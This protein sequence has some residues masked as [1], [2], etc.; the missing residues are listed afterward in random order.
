MQL[1]RIWSDFLFCF[2]FVLGVFR[3]RDRFL[4]GFLSGYSLLNLDLTNLFSFRFVVF[5]MK[6][7]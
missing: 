3:I 6:S 2:D 5:C 7:M 4:F 1:L